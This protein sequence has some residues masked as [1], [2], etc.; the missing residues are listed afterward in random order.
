[1]PET[2]G[3]TT[4]QTPQTTYGMTKAMGELLINDYTRKGFVDG[5]S[6]RLPTVIV[7]PG[8]PNKAASSFASG[9]IR[10]PLNGVECILPVGLDTI[11][12]V[13][14]YR[15]IVDGLVTLYE[16]R[17]EEIGDDR[18]FNFPSLS[19]SVGEM[20]ESLRRTAQGRP[21]GEIRVER[22]PRI[23]AI[24]ATWPPYTSAERALALGLPRDAN[25]D[26]IIGAYIADYLHTA[27]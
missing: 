10:E 17:S 14:G 24:V 5:R 21:L 15:T 3:D 8:A 18:A 20:I 26:A 25:I 11:M 19:V 4:K 13:A 16:A 12:P 27:K 1:M 7:R 9:V 23:E 6:A 22:D 2:V